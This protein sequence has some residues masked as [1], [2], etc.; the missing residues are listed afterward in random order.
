MAQ[1]RS[2]CRMPR[3]RQGVATPKSTRAWQE[4]MEKMQKMHRTNT[5]KESALDA[6]PHQFPSVNSPAQVYQCL[7]VPH[8]GAT[9]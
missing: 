5:L 2:S 8:S 7:Q 4:E 6:L 9:P 1:R 3:L